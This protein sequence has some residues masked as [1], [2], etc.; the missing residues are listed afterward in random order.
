MIATLCSSDIDADRPFDLEY[1][2]GRCQARWPQQSRYLIVTGCYT[3]ALFWHQG[4]LTRKGG[5]A[6][7]VAAPASLAR[8]GL[9]LVQEMLQAVEQVT[10]L[11]PL[12]SQVFT[13]FERE[14]TQVIDWSKQAGAADY[15]ALAPRV[16]AD[17][18]DPLAV[19]LLSRC[20]SE[21]EMMI[22]ACPA[23]CG[24]QVYLSGALAQACFPYVKQGKTA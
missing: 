24:A 12:S 9:W 2:R 15:A 14:I 5:E 11:T 13:H 17:S 19:R 16:L 6:F 21:L 23:A 7:P 4:V 8:L 18:Q 20:A 10:P 1:E 3:R 22:N